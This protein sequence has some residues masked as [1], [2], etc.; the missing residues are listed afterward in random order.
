MD[1]NAS[2]ADEPREGVIDVEPLEESWWPPAGDSF[3]QPRGLNG[4]DWRS[5]R[6]PVAALGAGA[7]GRR[8][9]EPVGALPPAAKVPGATIEDLDGATRRRFR[10]IGAIV[11]LVIVGAV[12]G[13]ALGHDADP[14]RS[15]TA[16]GT[17][18]STTA[19]STTAPSTTAPSTTV[20]TVA[21]TAS[22]TSSTA[23]ATTAPATT[24]P[25]TTTPA[26]TAVSVTLAVPVATT[27][28]SPPV[29][30]ATAGDPQALDDLDVRGLSWWGELRDG[31]ILL[32]GRIA[33]RAERD[34]VKA[35]AVFRAGPDRVVEQLVIDPTVASTTAPAEVPLFITDRLYF[36]GTNTAVGSVYDNLVGFARFSLFTEPGVSFV[37]VVRT[38]TSD[39]A[40]ALARARGQAVVDAVAGDAID[41]SRVSV[42]TVA[43]PGRA[44]GDD[45]ELAR[46][47]DAVLM[48]LVGIFGP[49][50]GS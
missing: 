3:P 6:A 47:D 28:S 21:T 29:T 22:A 42:S 1:E 38:P 33:S 8:D 41:R 32:R 16:I 30:L 10:W 23:P 48:V 19:P 12:V 17:G 20:T 45:A 14:D 50:P 26:T 25:A 15:R 39:A 4:A 18:P 40:S 35:N 24:A 13:A 46:R 43:A 7:D 5:L 2:S 49:V 37:A 36:S 31:T 34:L 9:R 44:A 27:V 11:P